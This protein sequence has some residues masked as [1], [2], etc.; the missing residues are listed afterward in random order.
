MT[1]HDLA[2]ALHAVAD[3]LHTF[4]HVANPRV[5]GDEQRVEV[6]LSADSS[7]ILDLT[8][9]AVP[10]T[11][12]AEQVEQL[13]AALGLPEP[14]VHDAFAGCC[15]FSASGQPAFAPSLSLDVWTVVKAELRAVQD[16]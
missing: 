15:Y 12:R 5:V 2:R 10:D 14:T 11:N 7:D 9:R 1:T 6:R 8:D 4:P 3:A 16:A 13:A